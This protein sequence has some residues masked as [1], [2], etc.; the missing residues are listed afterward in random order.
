MQISLQK[1]RSKLVKGIVKEILTKKETHPHG[2]LVSLEDG[3]IGR[4]KNIIDSTK[5]NI[6]SLEVNSNT[7]ESPSLKQLLEIGET[8][9]IEFKSSILWSLN[10]NESQLKN[11]NSYLLNNFGR[12]T[13]LIIIA[14]TIAAFLNSEGGYLLVGIKENKETNENEIIGIESEFIKLK[15]PTTDGFRRK[16]VDSIL[17]PY[18]PE[19]VFNHLTS[20]L[21][22]Q[23]DIIQNKT[24]CLIKV[25]KSP[26][27]VFLKINNKDYFLIRTDAETRELTG[28][29]I[30]DYCEERF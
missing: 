18:F 7:F 13:S 26:K 3:N 4:V 27:K 14:R 17:K 10:L 8:G 22:I 29:S 11:S 9:T 25:N 5:I 2:I 15:D 1:N 23:F 19:Y 21:S 16:I 24:I 6:D 20:Y 28:R 30:V 12:K